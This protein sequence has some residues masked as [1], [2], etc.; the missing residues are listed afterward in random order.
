MTHGDMLYSNV[1]SRS[2]A[3]AIRG[4]SGAWWNFTTGAYE[5]PAALD[6]SKHSQTMAKD[7]FCPGLQSVVIPAAAAADPAACLIECLAGFNYLAATQC[8]WIAITGVPFLSARGATM[9]FF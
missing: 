1:D 9:R 7:P 4:T 6:L 5:T 8:Y 3:V 2:L